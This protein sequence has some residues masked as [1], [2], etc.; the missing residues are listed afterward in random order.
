LRGRG[1]LHQAARAGDMAHGPMMERRYSGGPAENV[2]EVRDK[3]TSSSASTAA[4]H[5]A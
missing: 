3:F 2:Q 4:A 1:V 5:A